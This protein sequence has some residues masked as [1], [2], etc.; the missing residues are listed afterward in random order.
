MNSWFVLLAELIASAGDRE[1]L[2]RMFPAYVLSAAPLGLGMGSEGLRRWLCSRVPCQGTSKLC[3][4][5]PGWPGRRDGFRKG[6]RMAARAAAAHPL[7]IHP[8]LK[9]HW[10][11]SVAYGELGK[12]HVS[13]S[14]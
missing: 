11:A 8:S 10:Y 6:P 4:G 14:V 1:F 13:R 12:G 5:S 7:C 3:W 9:I 2:Q